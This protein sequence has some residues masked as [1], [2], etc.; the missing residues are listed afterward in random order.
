MTSTTPVRKQLSKAHSLQMTLIPPTA[1]VGLD[2]INLLHL[3]NTS[4][5]VAQLAIGKNSISIYW[6][7]IPS[8]DDRT[9]LS[10]INASLQRISGVAILYRTRGVTMKV[11]LVFLIIVAV[12]VWRKETLVEG[13]K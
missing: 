3:L 6:E 2:T 5:D 12:K 8:L 7:A 11:P 10:P 13:L 1:V 4:Q 9:E